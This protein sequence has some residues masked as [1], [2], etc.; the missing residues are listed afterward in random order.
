MIGECPLAAE[1]IVELQNYKDEVKGTVKLLLEKL[2]EYRQ[3]AEEDRVKAEDATSK[4][5]WEGVAVGFFVSQ[6]VIEK[7]FSRL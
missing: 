4:R 5:Y 7:Y 2:E 6:V 3:K 1:A